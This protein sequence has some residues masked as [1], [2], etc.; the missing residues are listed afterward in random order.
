MDRPTFHA[1][2]KPYHA[3]WLAGEITALESLEA[4]YLAEIAH[5]TAILRAPCPPICRAYHRRA[6]ARY[7]GRL[8]DLRK[9]RIH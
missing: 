2:L 3:A 7:Y 5:H 6:R 4:E 9:R 1:P 8:R